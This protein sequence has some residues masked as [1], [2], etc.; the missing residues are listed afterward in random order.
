M[1][2]GHARNLLLRARWVHCCHVKKV[3]VMTNIP[4][5]TTDGAARRVGFEI[6]YA[7]VPLKETSELI[8]KLFGGQAEKRNA[9]EWVVKNTCFGEFKLEVDAAPIKE[10]AT[11]INDQS[12]EEDKL[13]GELASKA[14]ALADQALTNVGPKIAPLEIVAPPIAF[15]DIDALDALR[16]ELHEKDALGTKASFHYAFGLHINPEAASLEALYL[17]KHMQAFSLLHDL[18]RNIHGVDI[19]RR[20]SPYIEPYPDAYLDKVVDDA[21]APS[22][23]TL[24]R[25]YH[26]YNPSRNS[27]LDMLPVFAWLKPD[28]VRELYGADEKINSRPTFH[29]R[30]PNCEIANPGWSLRTEWRTWGLVE[31]VAHDDACLSELKALWRERDSSLLRSFKA[32]ETDWGKQV[33]G[34]LEKYD[35]IH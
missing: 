26:S 29:Y 22:I 24:I 20:I 3:I 9:A 19:A 10:I 25:D 17:L 23:E 1:L 21:Y 32:G 28:L 11:A 30:L 34:V 16:R 31:K 33:R 27:A 8:Q 14:T 7:N 4:Q 5:T 15:E 2:S 35:V 13:F 6:E 18:L 12:L